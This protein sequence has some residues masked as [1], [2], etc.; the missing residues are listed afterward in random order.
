MLFNFGGDS[1][2]RNS[3]VTSCHGV[4]PRRMSFQAT[5]PRFR[6]SLR[7]MLVLMTLFALFF[8][9]HIN[10][11]QQRRAAISYAGVTATPSSDSFHPPPAP[12]LLW[13]FGEQGYQ[14]VSISTEDRQWEAA[15]LHALFPESDIVEFIPFPE[16]Q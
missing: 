7:A 3:K 2:L 10:W 13:M 14:S 11:I 15:H 8:W 5:K 6:Y 16:D 12:G 1:A 4:S 9:Y